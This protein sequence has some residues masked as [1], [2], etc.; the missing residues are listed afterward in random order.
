M[1]L[2]TCCEG[3]LQRS[4]VPHCFTAVTSGKVLICNACKLQKRLRFMS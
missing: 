2:W 3:L 1:R 4:M